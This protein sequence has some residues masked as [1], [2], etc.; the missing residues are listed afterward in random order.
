MHI[1]QSIQERQSTRS[2]EEKAVE[3]EKIALCL[4]AARLAPSACNAQSWH[5]VVVDDPKKRDRIAEV[6]AS[7]GMNKFLKQAPAVIAVVLERPNFASWFGGL[8]KRKD[9]TLIDIGIA[10]EHICLQATALGLGSCIV[11]WFDEKRIKKLLGIP[12]RKHLVVLIPIGYSAQEL[13]PKSRKPLE[14][15]SSYNRYGEER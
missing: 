15:I 11:G 1:L 2:Y 10:V 5:F 9:Y 8:V 7:M 4:E 13:R 12:R 6:S 14:E 3:R